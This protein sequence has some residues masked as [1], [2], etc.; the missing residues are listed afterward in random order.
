[1][2]WL[3]GGMA[4]WLG[5][6]WDSDDAVVDHVDVR[7]GCEFTDIVLSARGEEV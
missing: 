3:V 5:R 6:T 1:M 4:D 2:G 7:L